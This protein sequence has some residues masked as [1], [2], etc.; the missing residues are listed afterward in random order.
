ML[1]AGDNP[2]HTIAVGAQL[3]IPLSACRIFIL[4]MKAPPLSR[5][6]RRAVPCSGLVWPVPGGDFP[7]AVPDVWALWGRLSRFVPLAGFLA[8]LNSAIAR[9]HSLTTQVSQFLRSLFLF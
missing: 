5:H 3:M 8:K 7:L 1:H 6:W 4:H 2:W 9:A